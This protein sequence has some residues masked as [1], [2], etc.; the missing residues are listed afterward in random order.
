MDVHDAV[1]KM[2]F[3]QGDAHL[4]CEQQCHWSRGQSEDEEDAAAK[5]QRHKQV[6]KKTGRRDS[7]AAQVFDGAPNSMGNLWVAVDQE[8]QPKRAA[9]DK[10]CNWPQFIEKIH[11]IS[12]MR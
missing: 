5:L 11:V 6:G 10:K 7:N 1:C 4:D 9:Q 8:Y 2:D 3:C 12:S